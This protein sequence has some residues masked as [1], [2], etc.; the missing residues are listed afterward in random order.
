MFA[1]VSGR[2]TI[3]GAAGGDGFQHYRMQVGKGLNPQEWL[4][5]GGDVTV[6]V[7]EGVLA[8]WDTTGLNGLYAVQLLVVY[9]DDRVATAT[10][11]V[12]IR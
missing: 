11:Q 3:I 8:E 6:P 12:T 5:L 1:E 7:D 9:T 2:V 10:I 4:L